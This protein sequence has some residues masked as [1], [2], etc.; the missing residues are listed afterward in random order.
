MKKKN[1][2]IASWLL[3]LSA[4]IGLG[5]YWGAVMMFVDPSGETLGMDP[6]LPS[7]AVLPFS[8][9]LFSDFLFSG[10]ALLFVNGVSNTVAWVLLK[11]RSVWGAW[12]QL[13]CGVMLLLWLS[14]QWM[15]FDI[16]VLTTLYSLLS[17]CQIFLSSRLVSA[18]Q[19]N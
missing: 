10:F 6:I 7:M 13:V 8:E 12:A 17:L 3:W 18:S 1:N 9:V 19:N 15:I 16:N 4:F 11:N 5:A 14:V 2:K